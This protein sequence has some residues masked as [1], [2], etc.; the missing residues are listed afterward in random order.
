VGPCGEDVG[1]KNRRKGD[2]TKE[3][4]H[5]HAKEGAGKE[6]GIIGKLAKVREMY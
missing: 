3:A 5:R 2:E 6:E 1:Y 4:A